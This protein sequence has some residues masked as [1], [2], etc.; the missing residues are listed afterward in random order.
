[1]LA[2]CSTFHD[3][4]DS[5]ISETIGEFEISPTAP[6][7]YWF[8]ADE[9]SYSYNEYVIEITSEP[10]NAKILWNGKYINRTP[11]N[12]PFTGEVSSYDYIVIKAIPID[13]GVPRGEKIL[14]GNKPLPRKIHFTLTK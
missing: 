1:L 10:V 11:T 9:N 5:D 13:P 3:I 8:D 6:N 7:D 4:Q 12:Y 14:T 2:G